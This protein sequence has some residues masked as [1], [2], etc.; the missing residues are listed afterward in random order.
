MKHFVFMAALILAMSATNQTSASGARAITDP[1]I[2][3]GVDVE[4]GEAPWVVSIYANDRHQCGASLVSPVVTY[5]GGSPK[6][7]GWASDDP[8]PTWAISAAHCF[9][10]GKNTDLGNYSVLTGSR[11]LGLADGG[12]R[13]S[14]EAVY[15]HP[16]YDS[17][18]LQNDIAVI[19]LRPLVDRLP[20]ADRRSIR[21]P[22]VT[23]ILWINQPYLALNA[24]GWGR[25][26]TGYA[27]AILQ[28]V[29]VP[30]V[31]N[32]SCRL[33]Y[34]NAGS[35]IFS[36]MMCAGFSSGEYDSC[37]GDSG[38]SLF[39]KPASPSPYYAPRSNESV[40]VGVVSWGLGCGTAEL[41]GVY[42]RVVDY[43]RWVERTIEAAL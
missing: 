21:L 24:V 11:N 19:Q 37:Q 8:K 22:E 41:Y 2:L 31:D 38:S 5:D 36:G 30:A 32:L 15:V 17:K 34:E 12:E 35:N 27:S 26:E 16:R 42:T 43:K 20:L 1:R 13:V 9:P 33:S 3:N 6:I 10:E 28:K 7:D 39:Y 14:L 4:P 40:L 29:R 23:D 25:T 18:T